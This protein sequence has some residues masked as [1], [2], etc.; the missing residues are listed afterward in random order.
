MDTSMLYFWSFLSYPC[1]YP[2]D[3]YDLS[4]TATSIWQK[5]DFVRNVLKAIEIFESFRTTVMWMFIETWKVSFLK[6]FFTRSFEFLLLQSE[7]FIE[8]IFFSGSLMKMKIDSC[9]L[10]WGFAL[11]LWVMV[12]NIVPI[13]IYISI[14][15]NIYV[16][17]HWNWN[18]K[19]TCHN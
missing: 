7:Q 14:H 19:L 2:F 9:H 11:A 16:H 5:V 17:G 12:S 18:L 15:L 3:S 8:R 10:I 1:A 13:P 6:W 4:P